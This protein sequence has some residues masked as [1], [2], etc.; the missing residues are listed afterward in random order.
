[1][2]NLLREL[3]N[4]FAMLRLPVVETE[5]PVPHS[6][7]MGWYWPFWSSCVPQTLCIA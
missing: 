3:H 6:R 2:R 1:M 7:S 4:N 5:E